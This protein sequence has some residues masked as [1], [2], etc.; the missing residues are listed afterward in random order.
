MR[1]DHSLKSDDYRTVINYQDLPACQVIRDGRTNPI[2]QAIIDTL[3]PQAPEMLEICSRSGKI[4]AQ[5]VTFE[6]TIVLKIYPT[7]NYRVA[8]KFF[9]RMDDNIVNISY[10]ARMF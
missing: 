4:S 5:N 8:L 10:T 9:D 6:D 2:I 1:V 7:G 3:R